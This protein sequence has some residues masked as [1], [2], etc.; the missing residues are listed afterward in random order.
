[1][2]TRS[3]T[4]RAEPTT[5][6]EVMQQMREQ[7]PHK[8]KWE[9]AMLVCAWKVAMPEVVRSRTERMFY[10][11]GKFFVQLSSAPLRQ[12][13]GLNKIKVLELLRGHAQ[14]C[15]LTDVVFL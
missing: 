5:L 3:N 11:Q 9:E 12:E 4:R 8:R 14:G 1:M 6:Q 13:L 2:I 15:N 7:S 10:K